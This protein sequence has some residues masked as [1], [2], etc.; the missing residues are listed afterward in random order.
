MTASHTEFLDLCAA[1]A[2]DSL[3]ELDERRLERH[4]KECAPC[5]LALAEFREDVVALAATVAS[6]P[7]PKLKARVL[8]MIGTVPHSA[9]PPALSKVE[10]VERP[11]RFP[12]VGTL[13]WVLAA[14][15]ALAYLRELQGSR[16]LRLNLAEVQAERQETADQLAK[17]EG[18]ISEERQ[19]TELL[20][21][22]GARLATLSRTEETTGSLEGWALVDSNSRR[23]ILVFENLQLPTDRD[24][25]AWAIRDG[26]PQ[27]LG[28]LT[29]QENGRAWGG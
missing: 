6:P 29:V 18:Q 17:A 21:S 24:F 26:K 19:W 27:S 10:R 16:Q 25:E 2:L 1:H 12:L 7:P 4:L 3:D 28:L 20:G 13:G 14:L 9:A 15:L 8:G 5:E 11:S 23:A 22:S